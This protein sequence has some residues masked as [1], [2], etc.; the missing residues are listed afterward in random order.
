[1]PGFPR[2]LVGIFTRFRNQEP[3]GIGTLFL[4]YSPVRIHGFRMAIA[5][6]YN[7]TTHDNIGIIRYSLLKL[8]THPM[9]VQAHFSSN[10]SNKYKSLC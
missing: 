7:L 9:Y 3:I 1:M 8:V 4:I 6:D 2:C 10:D 5:I